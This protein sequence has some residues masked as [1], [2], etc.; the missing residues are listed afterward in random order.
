MEKCYKC[1]GVVKV[2]YDEKIKGYRHTCTRC[3]TTIRIAYGPETKEEATPK[4][5]DLSKSKASDK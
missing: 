5:K 4:V 3:D 1:N 2:T